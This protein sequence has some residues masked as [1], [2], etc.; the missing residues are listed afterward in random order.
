MVNSSYRGETRNWDW[1]RHTTRFM[2]HLA[3]MRR[4]AK[5]QPE[6]CSTMTDAEAVSTFLG[7]IS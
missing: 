5:L 6:Q 4:I 1:V 2:E 7:T 3:L